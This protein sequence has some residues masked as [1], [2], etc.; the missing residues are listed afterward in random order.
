MGAIGS[1]SPNRQGALYKKPT[2]LHHTSS[3]AIC[4]WA[5]LVLLSVRAAALCDLW[6]LPLTLTYFL[7]FNLPPL[8]ANVRWEDHYILLTSSAVFM[9]L[10]KWI[11]MAHLSSAIRPSSFSEDEHRWQICADRVRLAN[12]GDGSAAFPAC[13]PTHLTH[14]FRGNSLAGL[15]HKL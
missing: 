11:D 15:L 1:S 10:A 9:K 4:Q 3:W 5:P 13:H 8:R 7:T 14:S 6:P 12:D 2:N